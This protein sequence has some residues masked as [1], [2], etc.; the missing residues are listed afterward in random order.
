M[1]GG[2][3]DN[4]AGR[5][6]VT[7]GPGSDN[8][9]A[10]I[11]G[12]RGDLLSAFAQQTTAADV[13][14]QAYVAAARVRLLPM[15]LAEAVAPASRD[16]DGPGGAVAA[17][18]VQIVGD[19]EGGTPNPLAPPE[20]PSVPGLSALETALGFSPPQAAGP[21]DPLQ[22]A[23]GMVDPSSGALHLTYQDL[24]IPARGQPL[25]LQRTFAPRQG[26][27]SAMGAG[28]AFSYGMRLTYDST[29]NPMIEEST[30]VTTHFAPWQTP[31]TY[32][33]VDAPE[34]EVLTIAAGGSARRVMANGS[35]QQFDS[36]GRLVLLQDRAGD[37]LTLHYGRAGLAS[38]ED[39]AGRSLRFTLDATGLIS[40]VTDPTGA[41]LHFKH[42]GA[43]NLVSVTTA[44]GNT[45]HYTYSNPAPK[46]YDLPRMT[47]VTF[48]RGGKIGFSYDAGARVARIA[49]PGT[50]ET[51]ITYASEPGVVWTYFADATGARAEIDS[52]TQPATL[53]CETGQSVTCPPDATVSLSS[54]TRD[55]DP[56][57]RVTTLTSSP[58][59]SILRDGE[60]H[61][62]HNVTVHLPDLGQSGIDPATL[63]FS[64]FGHVYGANSGAISYN[65]L[66]DS[67]SFN[68]GALSP[69]PPQLFP[70]GQVHV[71]LV[72]AA[73]AAGNHL[74]HPLAWSYTLDVPTSLP[75][76][77]Q[78]LTTRGGDEPSFSP[79]GTRVVFVSSRQ[80]GAHLWTIDA[81]DVGE[82]EGT[83]R[84]LVSGAGTDADPAWSP[85]GSSIVLQFHAGRGHAPLAGAP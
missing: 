27:S 19:Q 85:D 60:G 48:P 14:P 11:A 5:R 10:D 25:A 42:D 21:A 51:T 22:F 84:M 61:V 33:A 56:S 35:S 64:A 45:T 3:R 79:D 40:A 36:Q 15:Q 74:A 43:G 29:G 32:R 66:D 54:Q 44:T 17:L 52:L 23:R 73:D 53:A 24:S 28:W 7:R 16:A 77:P 34:Q 39:A 75:G 6:S 18:A 37:G 63:Q 41:T 80:G 69:T 72:A 50:L 57:G 2:D 58:A 68:L 4:R 62:T 78:L 71:A 12:F 38:V 70:G 46:S 26:F 81:G 13:L 31:S 67:A 83:A 8:V 49:G 55:I 65:T 82:H 59:V 20:A 47:S 9:A 30:G 76:S 1:C